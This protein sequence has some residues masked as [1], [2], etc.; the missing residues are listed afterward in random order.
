MMRPFSHRCRQRRS[1]DDRMG[2]RRG[3][4]ATAKILSRNPKVDVTLKSQKGSLAAQLIVALIRFRLMTSHVCTCLNV[5]FG[6]RVAFLGPGSNRDPLTAR[7]HLA[8]RHC[9]K[10]GSKEAPGGS[11]M[12]LGVSRCM[13]SA[14]FG[15]IARL[16][17]RA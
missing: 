10:H 14:V 7:S 9:Q 5:S 3:L 4:G 15:N 6:P 13:T 1:I 12:P 2:K 8:F 11:R 17:G 16:F